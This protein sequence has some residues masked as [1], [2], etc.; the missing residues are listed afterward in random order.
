MSSIFHSVRRTRAFDNPSRDSRRAMTKTRRHKVLSVVY[1]FDG[2]E[3]LEGWTL[4]M[5]CQIT[6]VDIRII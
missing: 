2:R 1:S 5:H 4:K 6:S 3:N